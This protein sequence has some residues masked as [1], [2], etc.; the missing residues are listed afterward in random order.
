[1]WKG[2][3]RILLFMTSVEFSAS[4]VWVTSPID[5]N[6]R[7]ESDSQAVSLCAAVK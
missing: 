2:S 6:S 1:L 5:K 3:M 4:R 7:L